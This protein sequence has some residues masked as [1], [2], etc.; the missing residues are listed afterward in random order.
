M[1]AAPPR[2]APPVAKFPVRFD[3]NAT[4]NGG[5]H[6]AHWPESGEGTG[7]D[8]DPVSWSLVKTER[9]EYIA[10]LGQSAYTRLCTLQTVLIT[11]D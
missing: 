4:D 1:V 9:E 10:A 2:L 6:A 7:E 8:H 3:D 11:P 5:R